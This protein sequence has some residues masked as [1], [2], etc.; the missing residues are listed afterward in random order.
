MSGSHQRYHGYQRILLTV[1]CSSKNFPYLFL[2]SHPLFFKTVLLK[3]T[4]LCCITCTCLQLAV[5]REPFE[6][7]VPSSP[8]GLHSFITSL[9]GVWKETAGR[10]YLLSQINTLGGIQ[11]IWLS[12]T[13]SIEK[14]LTCPLRLAQQ[15]WPWQLSIGGPLSRL[16]LNKFSILVGR[17]AG[18]M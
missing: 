7:S 4:C 2:A 8:N 12:A 10:S 9:H 6:Q 14:A 1:K 16:F 13:Y 18:K 17:I 5:G 15:P 3:R 11:L